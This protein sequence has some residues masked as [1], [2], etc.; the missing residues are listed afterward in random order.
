MNK[1]IK[2]NNDHNL[3]IKYKLA[4]DDF[5]NK[6]VKDIYNN[7][8]N[9]K[10]HRGYLINL[11]NYEGIKN[12]VLSYYNNSSGI[13]ASKIIQSIKKLK[14][15][16]KKNST[17]LIN[18]L[19]NYNKYIIIN[20]SLWELLGDVGNLYAKFLYY[21]DKDLIVFSLDDKIQLVF[22]PFFD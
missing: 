13:S 6:Y 14:G 17:Y 11:E 20:S 16:K 3:L 9:Y 15:I 22:H 18:M 10:E 4:F 21:I 1:N 19:S 8:T 2:M 7:Y 12:K 5:E